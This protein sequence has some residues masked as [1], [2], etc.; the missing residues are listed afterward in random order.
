MYSSV[1]HVCSVWET[2]VLVWFCNCSGQ[3]TQRHN[4]RVCPRVWT[5]SFRIEITC[6]KKLAS[7]V[8]YRIPN[9]GIF[10]P[11]VFVV[12]LFQILNPQRYLVQQC[13]EMKQSWMHARRWG[14]LVWVFHLCEQFHE[15]CVET[16]NGCFFFLFLAS[17]TMNLE[18]LSC[19][20]K[21]GLLDY[22]G[23]SSGFFSI[24]YVYSNTVFEVI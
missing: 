4:T 6:P 7:F 11:L 12:R 24:C 20:F 2:F 21:W 16:T 10:N 15:F 17:R 18:H 13:N 22:L 8:S 1:K 9:K 5:S 3:Y 19:L 23:F 14:F